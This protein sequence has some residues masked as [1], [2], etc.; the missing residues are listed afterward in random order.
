MLYFVKS[1]C[2][3]ASQADALTRKV[4]DGDIQKVRGNIVF[5]STDGCTGYDI[6]EA[7]DEADLRSKYAPYRQYLEL[8]EVSPIAPAHEF[9]EKWENQRGSAAAA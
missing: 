8:V 7:D 5:L 1:Q 6:V 4:V 3:D 2:V 9:Y